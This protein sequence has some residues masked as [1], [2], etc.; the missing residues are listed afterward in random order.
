[1]T[2]RFNI[3]DTLWTFDLHFEDFVSFQVE[4]I[5]KTCED[6]L[7]NGRFLDQDCAKHLSDAKQKWL[8][9]MTSQYKKAVND[10]EEKY[11]KKVEELENARK[12]SKP[13][14]N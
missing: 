7:Y 1:M 8:D 4:S 10:V 6:V 9:Y 14:V 3:G 5:K 12:E 2:N 11:Y 13:G